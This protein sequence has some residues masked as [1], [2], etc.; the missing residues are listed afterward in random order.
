MHRYG[1][2]VTGCS[3]SDCVPVLLLLYGRVLQCCG[4]R[5][6]SSIWCTP[7]WCPM[8]EAQSPAVSASGLTAAGPALRCRQ[9]VSRVSD[10]VL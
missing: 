8:G 7:V 3:S 5:P 2:D 4:W 6:P 10:P 1:Y 9:A